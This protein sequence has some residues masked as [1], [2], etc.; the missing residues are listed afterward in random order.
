[1]RV[2]ADST[3]AQT[4]TEYYHI[5]TDSLLTH[6]FISFVLPREFKFDFLVFVF[7]LIGF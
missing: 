6:L 4:E 3:F 2:L 7:T 1:M 5:F